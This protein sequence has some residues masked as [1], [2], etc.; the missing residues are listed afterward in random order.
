MRNALKK[1]SVQIIGVIVMIPVLVIFA[2]AIYLANLGGKLPWQTDPTRI[3]VVAFEGLE[4][5]PK[6]AVRVQ[7]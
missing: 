6:I 5:G 7:S 4:T 2:Y 1:R 3:P